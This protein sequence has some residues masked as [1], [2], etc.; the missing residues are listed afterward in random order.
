MNRRTPVLDTERTAEPE[1]EVPDVIWVTRFEIEA[2]T[3]TTEQAWPDQ[4]EYRRA[5]TCR[6]EDRGAFM[7]PSC[8]DAGYSISLIGFTHCPFCG[9]KLEVG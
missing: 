6:W 4:F 9:G 2:S 8:R 1:G 3:I 5:E 7:F